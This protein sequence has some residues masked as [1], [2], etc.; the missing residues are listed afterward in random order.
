[1]LPDFRIRQ[2]DYLLEIARALTLELDLSKL[3]ERI[4]RI[5]VEML[6]GQSGM[7]ALRTEQGGW[8]IAGSHGMPAG[9]LKVIESF[10]VRV[11]DHEDPE[12]FEIPEINRAL[13]GM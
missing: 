11:P 1:M 7:I 3:L 13:T 5:A 8:K 12:R 2:R 10:L 9:F 4:I 6:A